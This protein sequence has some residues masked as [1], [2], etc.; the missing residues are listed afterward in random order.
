[1]FNIFHLQILDAN[2]LKTF[3]AF[4]VLHLFNLGNRLSQH[5]DEQNEG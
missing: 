3:I 1:M 4:M 5:G 2:A